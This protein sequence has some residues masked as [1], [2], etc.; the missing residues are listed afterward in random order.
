MTAWNTDR[1]TASAEP[2][3]PH[4]PKTAK[5]EAESP[6]IDYLKIGSTVYA[7]KKV[8]DD[9]DI[10][11]EV[12]R[13]YG[14]KFKETKERLDSAVV[15]ESEEEIAKLL[16]KIERMKQKGT[17]AIPE[18]MR[19]KTVMFHP[20]TKT[21]LEARPILFHPHQVSGTLDMLDDYFDVTRP[22]WEKA[23]ARGITYVVYIKSH[24]YLPG[25]ALFDPAAKRIYIHGMHTPHTFDDTRAC[26]GS[27]PTAYE[28]LAA[29]DNNQLSRH[30]STI[31]L[32]SL[33]SARVLFN[34]IRIPL[35]EIVK[36]DALIEVKETSKWTTA[37]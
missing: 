17:V 23:K 25:F 31:N 15:K 2:M 28:T 27:A 24:L 35:N 22:A 36:N 19:T 3:V 37:S 7:I 6:A 34:G 8:A 18:G 29:M 12:E 20:V 1:A 4:R 26:I 9:L 14:A 30:L 5:P 33:A 13:F 32:F 10:H 21:V 11:K 16:L